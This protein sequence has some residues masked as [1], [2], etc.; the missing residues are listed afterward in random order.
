MASDELDPGQSEPLL[1]V[2]VTRTGAANV[3][4]V[5]GE[6][7][8]YSAR[9]L[10]EALTATDSDTAVVVADLDGVSFMGS[11]GLAVLHEAALRVAAQG[12]QLRLAVS[13]KPVTRA[14]AVS[15]LTSE[16]S[17]YPSVREALAA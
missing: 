1:H 12:V 15:G 16:F 14:L 8:M 3:V 4:T 13:T 5:V 2:R 6:L 10:E 17:L 7:D 11:V 9:E